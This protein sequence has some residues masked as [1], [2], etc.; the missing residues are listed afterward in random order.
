MLREVEAKRRVIDVH[1][2]YP[3]LRAP[4]VGRRDF[5]CGICA[6]HPHDGGTCGHATLSA[7]LPY[8]DHPDYDPEWRP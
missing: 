2:H 1:A 5:G 4:S 8:A 7:R 3:A 6:V